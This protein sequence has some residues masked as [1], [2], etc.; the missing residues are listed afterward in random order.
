M[1]KLL[2]ILT[3]L[4]DEYVNKKKCLIGNLSQNIDDYKKELIRIKIYKL[5]AKINELEETM[6]EEVLKGIKGD[7]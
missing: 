7:E 3:E 1:S 4:R 6:N 2:K 5:N